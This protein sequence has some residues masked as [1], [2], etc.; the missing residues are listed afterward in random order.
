MSI[1]DLN[2]E[3]KITY[4]VFGS[5]ISKMF[6]NNAPREDIIEYCEEN[7]GYVLFE[8]HEGT[9]NSGELLSAYDGWNDYAEIT[10]EQYFIY[11]QNYATDENYEKKIKAILQKHQGFGISNDYITAI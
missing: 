6:A 4:Y 2:T 8:F 3:K 1:L 9:T 10:K 5:E 11:L 7:G